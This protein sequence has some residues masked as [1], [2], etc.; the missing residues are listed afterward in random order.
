MLLQLLFTVRGKAAGVIVVTTKRG[1]NNNG[2]A[3]VTIDAKYGLVTRFMPDYKVMKDAGQYYEVMW[4]ALRNKYCHIQ[5]IR[6]RYRA[7]AGL[8]VWRWRM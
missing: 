7:A 6:P 8:E 2:K 4:D 5:A 1:K 3:K